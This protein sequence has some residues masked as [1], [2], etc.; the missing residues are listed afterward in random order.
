MNTKN[1]GIGIFIAT[2][3]VLLALTAFMPAVSAAELHV[4]VGQPYT[5]IQAA[6]NAAGT[7]NN[8]IIV[9]NGTYKENLIVNKSD[10]VIRSDNGSSVTIISSNQTDMHVVNITDQTNVTLEGFT[11]RDARGTTQ[12]VAGIYM[13]NASVCNISNNLVTNISTPVAVTFAYGIYLKDSSNNTFSSSTSVSNI[14]ATKWTAS[15]IHLTFSSNNTFSS[16]T[17]V[18]NIIGNTSAEGISL[19]DSDNNT[20]NSSTE[21]SYINGTESAYGIRLN[22]DSENN[23][24]SSSTEVS[25][26]NSTGY[27]CGIGFSNLSPNNWFTTTSVSNITGNE[28][29][30]GIALRQSWD[31]TFNSSTEVS[32]INATYNASGIYLLDSDHTTFN[33]ASVTNVSANNNAY[34]IHLDFLS[35]YNTFDSSTEVS[36]V[37][38]GAKAYGILLQDDSDNNTFSAS[39]SVS[40]IKATTGNAYGIYLEYRS[41]NNTFSSSTVVTNVTASGNAYGIELYWYSS[42]NTFTDFTIT[43]ITSG[44]GTTAY[45]IYMYGNSGNNV[46]SGGSIYSTGE[47][48][49][50]YAVWLENCTHNTINESEIR[51]NGH[52]FWLNESDNNTIERNTIVN[53][54]ALAVSGVHLTNGSDNNEIHEN[55]FYENGLEHQALDDGTPGTN[56]W[57]GNF[58]SDYVPPPPYRINGTANSTDSDPL[59]CCPSLEKPPAK[60]PTLTPVGIIALVG[61]LSL[62]AALTIT[63]R[64]RR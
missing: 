21:V 30:E 32:Q 6:I 37:N 20:F 51:D 59:P 52:G 39:T 18:F 7:V 24:F 56:N 58:W 19:D 11:I 8:T 42:N 50:D 2:I 17:S 34:G 45:G 38:G 27:A 60:V 43:E 1:K 48:R 47:P 14:T 23:S 53:N 46:F 54:T 4:G 13:N 44:G 29:A 41:N 31:N 9:H 22:D 62:I 35:E 49:I 16:S 64:K 3:M 28:T 61:V 55:C 33:S 10:I 63:K 12:D 15:G 5:S 40:N 57:D 25:N 26:I 36:H